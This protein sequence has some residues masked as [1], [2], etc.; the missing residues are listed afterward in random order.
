ME[1]IKVQIC[2]GTTC[3]VMGAG[4]LQTMSEE[5][6]RRFGDKVEVVGVTCLGVC[7]EKGSFSKAPFV[8]VGEVLIG[9]ADFDKVVAEIEKQLL[10]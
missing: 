3:F 2:L 5:L 6:I 10:S 1:K 4:A 7:N 9:E 8:K